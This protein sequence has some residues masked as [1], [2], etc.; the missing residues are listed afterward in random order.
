MEKK[1]IAE[2]EKALL[3]ATKCTKTSMFGRWK[4]DYE[5]AA[6]EYEKAAVA[7]RVAKAMPR[8]ID[9]FSKAADMHEKFDSGYMA[10]KHMETAAFLAGVG[11]LKE[12][13]QSA[14]LYER[15][16]GLHR[17]DGRVENAAECLGKGAR[18]LEGVDNARGATLATEACD[19]Y[20]ED[21][22]ADASDMRTI[23]SLEPCKLAVQF[24]LRT[25]RPGLAAPV[26]RRQARVHVKL[27]Q[28][29]NVAKC[30]LSAVVVCLAADEFANAADGCSAAQE[31]GDGFAGTDEAQA[32]EELLSAYTSQS[33][34]ALAACLGQS[35]FSFLDNQ[36]SLTAK[37]LT[38]R[39]CGV[40]GERLTQAYSSNFGGGGG[41]SG[42]GSGGGGGAKAAVAMGGG[43]ASLGEGTGDFGEVAPEE[44]LT[45]D[46]C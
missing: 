44:E 5:A 15:A 7:F 2:A 41:S 17:I 37:T 26:L 30:E 34:E 11:G 38:L 42:G 18:A 45:E 16:A 14:E 8:A 12:P 10:A 27:E 24:H 21:V 6:A 46:L 1:K 25:G 13:L 4:P 9:A 19:L 33:E 35:V 22:L 32:A 36:V 43:A 28:P 39:S 29:H 31:R 40:P 20:D 3:D 23:Q